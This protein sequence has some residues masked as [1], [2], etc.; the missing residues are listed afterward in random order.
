MSNPFF[1]NNGPYKFSE[2][3][4]D[5]HLEMDEIHKDLKVTDIK[6]LQNSKSQVNCKH[7]N[8]AKKH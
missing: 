1:E 4:H 6:D 8:Y 3:L 2:I 5:L 7:K